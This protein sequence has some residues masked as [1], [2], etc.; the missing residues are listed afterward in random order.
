M[1]LCYR[2]R[3]ILPRFLRFIPQQQIIMSKY[4]T[5]TLFTDSQQADCYA[6]FRPQYT[7]QVFQRIID[8][9]KTG[10]SDFDLAVDVGC[11][12]GQS[13][14]PLARYF[15]KVIGVDVSEQQILN[16]PTNIP[17]VTFKVSSAEDLGF[18]KAASTDLVTIAQAFHWVNE[19]KFFADVSR[20]L[21]PGGS[22]VVYGYGICELLPKE[23]DGVFQHYYADVLGQ[24]WAEG[25]QMVEEKYATVRLPFPGWIRDD[26]LVI[27]KQCS[28]ADFIGYMGS[29]SAII[30]YNKVNPDDNLLKQVEQRLQAVCNSDTESVESKLTVVWPV[31]MLMGHKPK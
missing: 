18:V 21:K 22:L 17:N 9:C 11:G 3:N 23:A 28:V 31:F 8:F 16:A 19:D 2:S 7:D 29:W 10:C 1:L 24:Y 12:S 15:R 6:K 14:V 26:S 30:Q 5:E 25:R 20:I 27:E 4:S 13:T